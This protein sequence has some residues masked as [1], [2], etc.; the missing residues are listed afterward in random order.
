MKYGDNIKSGFFNGISNY[1]SDSLSIEKAVLQR[2]VILPATSE[3]YLDYRTLNAYAEIGQQFLR[4]DDIY[5]DV[6]ANFYM[7]LI[8]PMVE[9]GESTI[10]IHDAPNIENVS[11]I[12]EMSTSEYKEANYIPLI[13]PK[14]IVMNFKDEIPAQTE[15]IVNFTGGTLNYGNIHIMGVGNIGTESVFP[16]EYKETHGMATW[17]RLVELAAE[18]GLEEEEVS[19][20]LEERIAE[21]DAMFEELKELYYYNDDETEE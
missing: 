8:F 4:P 3:E 18:R 1:F 5:S 2:P 20:Y 15:F 16:E 11:S 17:E 14:Y 7:P 6:K 13:I 21:R 9:N 10:M 19:I 12:G